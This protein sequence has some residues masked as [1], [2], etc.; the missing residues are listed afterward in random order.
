M[1][2]GRFRHHLDRVGSSMRHAHE[3]LIA[4][5][6]ARD[7]AASFIPENG[8]GCE[9]KP[10]QAIRASV[11]GGGREGVDE[12]SHF[13]LAL[14][15]F[16]FSTI[17]ML[18]IVASTTFTGSFRALA[19]MHS[20]ISPWILDADSLLSPESCGTTRSIQTTQHAGSVCLNLTSWDVPT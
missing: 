9:V 12:T 15:A 3:W 4:T 6:R 8:S 17:D 1:R 13:Q 14:S 11:I 20:W 2:R 7:R 18:L 16:K 10:K 19:C 5:R